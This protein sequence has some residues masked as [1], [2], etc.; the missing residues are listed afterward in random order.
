MSISLKPSKT[1]PNGNINPVFNINSF[2]HSTDYATQSDLLA[3][4]NLYNAN[5]WQYLNTFA[6][7]INFAGRIN[8]IS[9]TVFA[10]VAYLPNIIFELTNVSYDSTNNSTNITGTS[11][12]ETT[13]INTNCNIG[14]SLNVDT[15]VNQKMI[16]NTVQA[17]NL[18]CFNLNVNGQPYNQ[19]IAFIY[20]NNISIPL[21][22]SNLL[23]NFN[24][25]TIN[26]FYFTLTN[27]YRIDIVDVNDIIL[28][29]YTNTNNDFVYYQQLPFNASMYKINL[30]SSLNNLI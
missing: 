26:S 25:G 17:N 29:S 11:Y 4:G 13:S 30:Y 12:F 22:K 16:T 7:G 24:I 2:Y 14:S 21:Q 28:Y 9:D 18:N 23:S 6:N 15:I 1:E 8:G 3:Y 10:L 19:I 5:F 27:S 20:L